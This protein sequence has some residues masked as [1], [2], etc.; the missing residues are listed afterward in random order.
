MKMKQKSN[1][2]VAVGKGYKASQPKA[3]G[4]EKSNAKGPG[5]PS[6]EYPT[7]ACQKK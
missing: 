2:G 7:P 5:Y 6:M 4:P 1:A 3:N